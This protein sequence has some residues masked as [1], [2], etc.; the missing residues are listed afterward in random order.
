VAEPRARRWRIERGA[1]L[2]WRRTATVPANELIHIL[3]GTAVLEIVCD[4]GPPKSFALR[5]GMMVVIP[6]GGWHRF[7]SSEGLTLMAA[8]PFTGEKIDLDVDD[9]RT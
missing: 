2:N 8:T 4:D 7:H 3:D 1:P 5:A 9:P 6:Q